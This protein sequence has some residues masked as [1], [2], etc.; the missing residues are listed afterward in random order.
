MTSQNLTFI[1]SLIPLCFLII[2][3]GHIRQTIYL[4][5]TLTIAVNC[6]SYSHQTEVPSSKGN[7]NYTEIQSFILLTLLMTSYVG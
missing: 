2:M 7:Y 5:H 1:P 4:S 3:T 6:V